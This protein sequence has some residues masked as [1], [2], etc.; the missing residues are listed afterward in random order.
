ME[1]VAEPSH[2]LVDEPV[3]WRV[4]GV[5]V[6]AEVT[7]QLDVTDAAD[8]RW[9]S[10]SSY[11]VGGD[12]VLVLPDPA[13]PWSALAP[14]DTR[15]A[16]TIFTPAL[17]GWSA[18]A[19]VTAG[20]RTA[21]AEVS[22]GYL[23]GVHRARRTGEGWFMELF[24]PEGTAEPGPGVLCVGGS[25][26]MTGILPRAA[27][28]ASHGYA[29]AVL[30]YIQEPGLPP[31]MDRIP[32]EVVH[33]ALAAFTEADPAHRV[34]WAASVG[35]G[36]AL[37]A[38][39]SP[40]A[41]RVA[42]A[43]MVAP[44]DVVW[45]ALAEGQP[46]Q[47]AAVSRGGEELPWLPMRSE[48]V[49]TQWLRGQVVSRLP[50]RQRST[51]LRLLQAYAKGRHDTAKLEAAT[52]P[53]EEIAA[54]IMLVAGEADAMWPAAEMA[55][56]VADRRREAGVADGDELHVLPGAGHFFD[57]PDSPATVDRSTGLVAGGEP[58]GTAASHRQVWDATLA[59]LARTAGHPCG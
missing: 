30:A 43:I 2:G 1:L 5:D 49:L 7:L 18:T 51:A 11:P 22:R 50:G 42:G 14:V 46:P 38:L 21:A 34:V 47:H 36:L 29:T 28:L 26:G 54:P 48:V 33:A 56:R 17:D 19:S 40:G 27:L 15:A 8:R 55:R 57:L 9:R 53:V 45:Q 6:G 44:T 20:G 32:V 25:M 12:G 35:C 10:A 59:F 39:A 16:P 3:S 37:A 52:I 23:R 58:V 4:T 31:T 24:L 41:P 13:A